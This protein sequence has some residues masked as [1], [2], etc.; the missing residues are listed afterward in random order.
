MAAG[1]GGC[2]GRGREPGV[3]ELLGVEELKEKERARV[4]QCGAAGGRGGL[5]A[6]LAIGRAL[7]LAV[8]WKATG[9]PAVFRRRAFMR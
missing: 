4:P 7:V 6:V 1:P 9:G 2:G 5:G 8:R 3:P